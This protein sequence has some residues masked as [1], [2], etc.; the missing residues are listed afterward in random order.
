MGEFCRRINSKRRDSQRTSIF[1]NSTNNTMQPRAHLFGQSALNQ[2]T[3]YQ[4]PITYQPTSFQPLPS[5]QPAISQP[6]VAYPPAP[7]PQTIVLPPTPPPPRVSSQPAPLQPQIAY[8]NAQSQPQITYQTA[9]SQPQITY[10]TAPS[11][12]QVAYNSAPYQQA[13]LHL[14]K[15]NKLT[16]LRHTLMYLRF[17][18]LCQYPML[19]CLYKVISNSLQYRS[20]FNRQ[21][22]KGTLNN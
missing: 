10:Q 17:I 11:Q 12:P 13:K 16:N 19:P 1:G 8:Q 18:K 4:P 20:I 3:Q 5:Y 7:Y 14:V 21:T 9:P 6:Q 2:S 15:Y 22:I